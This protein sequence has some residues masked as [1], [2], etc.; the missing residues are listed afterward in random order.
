VLK[1][2]RAFESIFDGRVA[3]VVEQVMQK[4]DPE[5]I[6]DIPLESVYITIIRN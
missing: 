4:I 6:V 2:K 3:Q 5:I 1:V